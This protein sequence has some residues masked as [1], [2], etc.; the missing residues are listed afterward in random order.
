MLSALTVIYFKLAELISTLVPLLDGMLN[1]FGVKI[2]YLSDAT[3]PGVIIKLF[4]EI[5][6]SLIAFFILAPVY[7]FYRIFMGLIGQPVPVPWF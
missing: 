7:I 3:D 4:F 2:L 5:V 6:I 1:Q